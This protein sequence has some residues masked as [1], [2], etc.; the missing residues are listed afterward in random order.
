[1]GN[2]REACSNC[3]FVNLMD[4]CWER[5]ALGERQV[6]EKTDDASFCHEWFRFQCCNAMQLCALDGHRYM[7]LE[8]RVESHAQAEM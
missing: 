7:P 2:T 6:Y 5:V 8:Q 1:M 3:V 4:T